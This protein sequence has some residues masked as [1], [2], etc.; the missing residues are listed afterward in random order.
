MTLALLREGDREPSA[1]PSDVESRATELFELFA[2]A[3]HPG[4]DTLGRPPTAGEIAT[5]QIE[6]A[7]PVAQVVSFDIFDTLVVRKVAA[8]RDVFLHLATPAPFSQWGVDSVTLA[9]LRQEAEN[10][11]REAAVNTRGSAEVL[12]HEIHLAL[13]ARLGRPESDVPAMARAE[14][15]VEL[16]LCVAHPHLRSLFDRARAD[17]K[18]IWCVSDTYHGADFLRELL[19]SCGFGLDGVTVVSSADR[20]MSKGEGKLLSAVAAEAKFAH[21]EVLHIGDHPQSDFAI[22]ADRGFLAVLHP[23]AA[24]RHEDAISTAPGDAIALGLSQIG[25]R[26]VK[27]AF[28]FWWRFGYAVAGPL[29]SGFA[30]W[31]HGKFVADGIDRA[32]FLLRDGEIILDVY[33]ALLGSQSGPETS[34]L[35]SSRRAFL[36]PALASNRQSITQQLMACENARPAREFIERFG[37]RS[38]DFRGIFRTVGLQIDEV[39]R[40]NDSV[41]MRKI[42]TLFQHPEILKAMLARSTVERGLLMQYLK[43]ERVLDPGRVALVDIGWNGTIQK[44]LMGATSVENVSVDVHGYYLGTHPAINAD[45][46]TSRATGFL[47][48]VGAPAERYRPV[49]QLA[50]LVEFICSTARGSLR[51]FAREKSGVVPVHAAVD[52]SVAQRANIAHLHSGAIAYAT[53]LASEQRVFGTQPISAGAALRNLARIITAPT[54]EEARHIGDIRHG[55]GLGADRVR[56]LAAFSEGGFTAESLLR[57][58]ANAYWPV[59]LLAR[60]EPAALALRAL[61]WLRTE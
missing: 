54:R 53:A 34:L 11:A 31:L 46:D 25:S 3:A 41:T 17:G 27:P 19:G 23:W 57:D 21:Q 60:R 45:L 40:P 37:L 38:A 59:G 14:Q 1:T 49:M 33:R 51:G 30:Q 58:H 12:L 26:T 43:Q 6:R 24:S 44:A 39:V 7:W 50:Q 20:R 16:A 28:P 56:A 22:P 42:F 13:A 4:Y 35:E 18:A 52:H 10:V 36:L 5:E 55:E 15:L 29:L 32:Y 9:L 61:L 8:P 47:F 48:D 2:S